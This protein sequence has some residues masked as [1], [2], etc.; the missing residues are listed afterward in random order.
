MPKNGESPVPSPY[1]SASEAAKYLRLSQAYLSM[2]RHTGKG[3]EY[4]DHG[5]IVYHLQALHDWCASRGA[6]PEKTWQEVLRAHRTVGPSPDPARRET[7]KECVRQVYAF[8]GNTPP[9]GDAR[10]DLG[11]DTLEALRRA[12]E[13]LGGTLQVVAVFGDEQIRLRGV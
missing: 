10:L 3:P 1:L 5:R 7:L 11:D 6:V 2:L 9:E 8:A 12:V 13:D 4:R